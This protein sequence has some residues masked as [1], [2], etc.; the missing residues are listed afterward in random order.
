M[1]SKTKNKH[2]YISATFVFV[3]VTVATI[4]QITPDPC[5]PNSMMLGVIA[6]SSFLYVFLTSAM[7]VLLQKYVSKKVIVRSVAL[8]VFVFLASG[9]IVARCMEFL[10]YTS[11]NLNS[12]VSSCFSSLSSNYL[13]AYS[14]IFWINAFGG[15]TL[16]ALNIWLYKN[17]RTTQ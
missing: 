8:I 1:F 4:F 9:F 17:D 12:D 5:W 16:A 6:A 11:R 13:L 15:L 14:D 7:S 10:D 3:A 2:F